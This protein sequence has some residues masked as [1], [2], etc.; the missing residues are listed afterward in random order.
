MSDPFFIIGAS[1]AG[2]SLAGILRKKGWADGIV[3]FER[4]EGTPVQRPPLS[5]SALK[6]DWPEDRNYIQSAE[7]Y[8]KQG[9]ELKTG[10]EVT[11]IDPDANTV[12]TN[13]GE[14]LSWSKLALATGA[15]PRK[16]NC[17]GHDLNGIHYVR[18]LTDAYGL[19]ADLEDTNRIVVIGGG[20]IGLE[21]AA[22]MRSLGKQVTVIEMADRL[23]ARVATPEMSSFFEN[24]HNRNGVELVTGEGVER[25][26]G[27]DRVTAVV[28]TSGQSIEAGAVVVGIGVVPDLDLVSCLNDENTN[29][30]SVNAQC[31]TSNPDIYA[32]GDIAKF[33]WPFASM[34]V[35]SIH[36]AQYTAALAGHHVMGIDP[37]TYEAPWFWS[38]QHGGKLQSVGVPMDWDE[39]VWRDGDN[40]DS[41]AAFSFSGDQLV[42][43]EAFNLVPAFMLGKKIFAGLSSVTKHEIQ[44]TANDLRGLMKRKD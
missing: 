15:V 35:E 27:S 41:G 17:P 42:S 40:E 14:T 1:H 13:Y 18:T 6:K 28:T 26:E 34:R 33:N 22:C 5:K 25:I 8:E 32:I 9:I 4:Q 30:I 36:N 44:D 24:L 11:A 12:T 7:W 39:V 20:Y 10:T 3:L 23:L 38:D 2:V 43:V 19:R 31:Q 29:G 16:I 37:P 21:A